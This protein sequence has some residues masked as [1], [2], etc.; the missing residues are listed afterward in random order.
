MHPRSRQATHWENDLGWQWGWQLKRWQEG[1]RHCPILWNATW[2]VCKRLN[3]R[4]NTFAHKPHFSRPEKELDWWWAWQWWNV[5]A[6]SL[7]RLLLCH[8]LVGEMILQQAEKIDRA[9]SLLVDVFLL[10]RHKFYGI[11]ERPIHKTNMEMF[12]TKHKATWSLIGSWTDITSC[13]AKQATKRG[14]GQ[15]WASNRK[16]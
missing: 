11:L 1:A 13:G 12:A 7:P 10:K 16:L 9:F 5:R 15:E 3:Q 8:K 4:Q 2:R 6:P 14:A